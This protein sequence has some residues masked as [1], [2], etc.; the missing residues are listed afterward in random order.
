MQRFAY[1]VPSQLRRRA[2]G[3]RFL[4]LAVVSVGLA[5]VVAGLGAV[6]RA[7]AVRA[8][9]SRA[10]GAGT[11][12]PDCSQVTLWNIVIVNTGYDYFFVKTSGGWVA[13]YSR[14]GAGPVRDGRPLGERDVVPRVQSV[15]RRLLGL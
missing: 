5:S 12:A 9:G 1:V 3:R 8:E 14:T 10:L 2:S 13:S 11:A 6:P 4:A 7:G 15:P